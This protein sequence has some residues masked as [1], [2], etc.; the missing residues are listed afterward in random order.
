MCIYCVCMHLHKHRQTLKLQ[1]SS[2]DKTHGGRYLQVAPATCPAAARGCVAC[3]PRHPR[4]RGP[5]H[6]RRCPPRPEGPGAGRAAVT[7]KHARVQPRANGCALALRPRSAPL[8]CALALRSLLCA[9]LT[10]TSFD[11]HFRGEEIEPQTISTQRNSGV[12]K[13]EGD[14]LHHP[15]SPSSMAPAAPLATM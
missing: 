3:Q 11:V 5:Q 14:D 1:Q 9:S 13:S 8:L 15:P 7:A 2:S 4:W 6:A 12:G 10:H